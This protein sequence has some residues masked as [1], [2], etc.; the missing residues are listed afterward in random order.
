MCARVCGQRFSSMKIEVFVKAFNKNLEFYRSKR[1]SRCILSR[2]NR[3]QNLRTRLREKVSKT[4]GFCKVCSR[5]PL[6]CKKTDGFLT[7]VVWRCAKTHAFLHVLL[8]VSIH[9][10]RKM[11]TFMFFCTFA[12]M[13]SPK[14][15]KNAWV[16]ITFGQRRFGLS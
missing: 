16:F 5:S 13:P 1:P 10:S 3:T 6:K 11:L 14:S 12:S 7:I 4:R 9:L 15:D 2:R 8:C